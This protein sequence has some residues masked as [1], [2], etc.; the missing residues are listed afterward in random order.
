MN[1]WTQVDSNKRRSFFLVFVFVILVIA[2][3]WLIS[4]IYN[5][6][7]I[8]IFAII[9]ALVQSLVGYFAGDK[10]VLATSGAKEIGKA[11]NPILW[12]TVENLTI[13]AGLPMPKVYVITDPAPNAFATGRD[14]EHASVAVTT[15][16]LEMLN[17]SE[18]EG[19][20][21]H[22]LSHVG[23]LDI[24]LMMMVAILVSVVA[25]VSVAIVTETTVANYC[26]FWV[27]WLQYWHH[28]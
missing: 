21:A 8:L 4:Y 6:P 11:G 1:L 9:I 15:G 2:L 3:G 23:N 28:L 22:E 17:K 20:V 13:A 10:I 24:R 27:L 14:P 12:N 25:L 5:S 19:V 26:L 7:A 18:L 16:L